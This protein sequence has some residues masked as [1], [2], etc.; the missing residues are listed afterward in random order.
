MKTL[1]RYMNWAKTNPKKGAFAVAVAVAAL[2]GMIVLIS[3][4][5]GLI[6]LAVLIGICIK[7]RIRNSNVQ[8][9]IIDQQI[10]NMLNDSII[11]ILRNSLY[12]IA[13]ALALPNN[14]DLGYSNIQHGYS[15]KKVLV[16]RITYKRIP[17]S[18]SIG[19]ST[20]DQYRA[21]INAYVQKT[22]TKLTYP[23]GTGWLDFYVAGIQEG[24]GELQIDCVP[25]TDDQSLKAVQAHQNKTQKQAIINGTG[26]IANN[27]TSSSVPASNTDREVLYDDE[28]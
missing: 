10:A 23:I 8:K 12:G 7:D 4:Y 26:G 11:Y 19:A 22:A 6:L 27:K 1:K 28:L 24:N 25:V 9:A 20:L 17:D 18:M 2:I 3:Y 21:I 16:I 15:G 13:S 14:A 5:A